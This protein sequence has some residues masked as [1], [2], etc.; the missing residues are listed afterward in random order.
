MG[1]SSTKYD[2]VI[3]SIIEPY[4]LYFYQTGQNHLNGYIYR[5][6][7]PEINRN[8]TYGLTENIKISIVDSSRESTVIDIKELYVGESDFTKVKTQKGEMLEKKTFFD[9]KTVI[10]RINLDNII[11]EVVFITK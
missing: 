6:F 8:I 5:H 7:Q 1:I 4:T 3:I 11:E 10:I 2:E 9:D